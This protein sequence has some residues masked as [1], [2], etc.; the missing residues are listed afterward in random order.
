MR[1]L[2]LA[3]FGA[4]ATALAATFAL[5]AGGH[6]ASKPDLADAVASTEAAVS[7]H[8]TIHVR[9]TRGEVPVSL[10]IRGQASRGTI[11]V[12]LRLGELRLDDGTV[13]PGPHGATLLDGPFLSERAPSNVPVVGNVR[14]L[15]MR[16]ASLSPGSDDLKAIRSMTPAPLLRVLRAAQVA[17]AEE[18]ARVF[19][20]TI[21]YDDAAIRRLAKLTGGTEFRN[22]RLSAVVGDDGLVH[23]MVLTGR[24]AD[25]AATFSLRAHFF[26]FG[27]PVH[28]TPPAP[29]TFVDDTPQ[30]EA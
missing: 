27:R 4:D 30:V 15:R 18:G 21:A 24:T 16:V 3:I 6:A 10:H 29:G 28:A 20:G 5:A 12:K 11:S 26:A 13:V 1:K 25:G 9:I 2:G 8:Y 17:P 22:L 23:R 19:H 14:W 7:Q